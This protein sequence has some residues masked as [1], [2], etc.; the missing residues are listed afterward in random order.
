MDTF[1]SLPTPGVHIEAVI[2]HMNGQLPD[3]GQGLRHGTATFI[4]MSEK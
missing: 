3:H 2:A 4:L 1:P